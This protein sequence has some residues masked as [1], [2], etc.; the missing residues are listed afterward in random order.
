MQNNRASLKEMFVKEVEFSLFRG[1][2]FSTTVIWKILAK[3]KFCM[4]EKTFDC[5]SLFSCP[6]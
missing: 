1:F 3:K 4:Q 2:F 6:R 5:N